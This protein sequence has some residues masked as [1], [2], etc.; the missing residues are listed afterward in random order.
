VDEPLLRDDV[1]AAISGGDPAF[2]RQLLARFLTSTDGDAARL[3]TAIRQRARA[4]VEAIAHLVQGR[5]KTLGAMTLAHAGER[6][7]R[8]ASRGEWRDIAEAH[9]RLHHELATLRREIGRRLP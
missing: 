1:L 5:C 8:A 3:A 7:E 9:A 4:R 2:E 6:L